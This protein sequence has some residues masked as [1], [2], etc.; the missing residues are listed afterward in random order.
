MAEQLNSLHDLFVTELRDILDAEHQITDAMPK[1]IDAASSPML[2]SRFEQHLKQTR[3]QITR[4]HEVFDKLQLKPEREPC[5]GMAGLIKEGEK[6]LDLPGYPNVKDAALIGAAQK[7]E[8]YEISAYGTLRTFARTLGMP[9]VAN[10]LQT[11][12]KEESGTD[13]MLTQLAERSVNK[14]AA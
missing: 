8:H 12:L 13:E 10:L 11:T 1:M 3:E 9:D 5:E 14:K 2:K 4:L 7:V 6:V